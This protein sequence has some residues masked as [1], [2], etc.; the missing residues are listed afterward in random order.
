R[1]AGARR[2][3]THT[4][5][6]PNAAAIVL[7]FGLAGMTV[8]NAIDVTFRIGAPQLEQAPVPSSLILPPPGA[9]AQAARTVE[10]VAIL[11]PHAPQPMML[12]VRMVEVGGV[13]APSY[14]RAVEIGS[15]AN[16]IRIQVNADQ[17]RYQLRYDSG[18]QT[19]FRTAAARPAPGQI[20]E[21]MVPLSE[22]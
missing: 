19:E 12:Y 16:R 13:L 7:M 1:L 15:G 5:S 18:G 2:T 14:D 11:W 17:S 22:A 10:T 9:P 6:D 8:G 3:H 4:V 20:V 21:L